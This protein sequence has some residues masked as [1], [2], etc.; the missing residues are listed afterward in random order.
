LPKINVKRIKKPL[1]TM[2]FIFDFKGFEKALPSYF[3]SLF[4]TIF[5]LLRSITL[6]TVD[7]WLFFSR[8]KIRKSGK[9]PVLFC[10]PYCFFEKYFG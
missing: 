10:E 9:F 7:S 8:Q 3:S 2:L 5:S 4:K 6:L 1:I